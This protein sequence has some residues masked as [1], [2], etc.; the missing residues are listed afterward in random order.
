MRSHDADRNLDSSNDPKANWPHGVQSEC[1]CSREK[2]SPCSS[3]CDSSRREHRAA[4]VKGHGTLQ[5]PA[6]AGHHG[7]PLCPVQQ[8]FSS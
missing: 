3:V 1:L 4:A 7:S 2:V 6:L 8:T 5:T